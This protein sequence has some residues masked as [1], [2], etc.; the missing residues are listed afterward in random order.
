MSIYVP[1]FGA[2]VY[3]DELADREQCAIVVETELAAAIV[4]PTQ[5]ERGALLIIPLRHRR[6]VLD[7]EDSE[8]TDIY[9]L[10][11]RLTQAFVSGL[12]AVGVN[13]F[14]NNGVKANQTVAHYHVHVVPRY[15]SSDPTVNFRSAEYRFTPLEQQLE[16]AAAIRGALQ[17][18]ARAT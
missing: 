7:V 3:C 18:Q 10:A 6:T 12:G 5:Y 15:E 1:D 11:K 17:A 8:L 14:Q 16:V 9:R 4:N 13:I 2:C